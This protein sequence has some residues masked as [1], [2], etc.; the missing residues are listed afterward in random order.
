VVPALAVWWLLA[1]GADAVASVG[2]TVVSVL[3]LAVAL[4]VDDEL[5]LVLTRRLRR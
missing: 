3:L 4:L 5:R 1:R 2:W